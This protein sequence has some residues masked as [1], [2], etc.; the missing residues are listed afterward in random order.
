ML[1]RM[2]GERVAQGGGGPAQSETRMLLFAAL[3][4]ADELHELHRQMPPPREEAPEPAADVLAR[5]ESLAARVEK[6][7]AHLEEPA[8]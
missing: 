5:I 8:T 6:L 4:L 1:G 2:V 3:M 7:A